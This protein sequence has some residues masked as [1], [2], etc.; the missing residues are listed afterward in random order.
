[1]APQYKLTYFNM[2][3]KA[4]VIRLLFA[5]AGVEY[6]DC[7]IERDDWPTEK[8]KVQPPFGQMPL[9]TVDGQTYCQSI[10]I[11]RYLAEKFGL[12]GGSEL[13]KLR[14]DMIV[15]CCEDMIIAF[16]ASFR[17]T[18]PERK[19][20]LTEKYEKEQLPVFYANFEKILAGNKG[21][22]GYFVGDSLTWADLQFYHYVSM[23]VTVTG[24]DRNALLKDAPKSLALL[25]R[26]EKHPKVAEWLAKRPVTN[27]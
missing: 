24:K 5:V 16:S 26:V 11:A 20:Q 21:G 4:E 27:M 2:R 3:G 19:A 14:A 1:M 22:D 8:E 7:R 10:S 23:Y 18:D 6:E 15:H 12:A 17:E 25:D 13:D 9:L